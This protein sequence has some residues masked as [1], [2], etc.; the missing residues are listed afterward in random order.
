MTCNHPDFCADV[1]VSRFEDS[2]VWYAELKLRCEICHQEMQFIGF[3]MG[4]SPGEPMINITGTELRIPF[5]SLVSRDN[6]PNESPIGFL[7]TQG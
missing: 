5:R 6:S 4:L 7:V 3:P 2:D 1:Q